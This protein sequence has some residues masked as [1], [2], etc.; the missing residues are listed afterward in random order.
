MSAAMTNGAVSAMTVPR[1]DTA[2]ESV[3]R[4]L[5]GIEQFVDDGDTKNLVYMPSVGVV[6]RDAAGVRVRGPAH[7]PNPDLYCVLSNPDVLFAVLEPN[8]V[9]VMDVGGRSEPIKPPVAADGRRYVD[10]DAAFMRLA[11]SYADQDKI[12]AALL[13][14]AEPGETYGYKQSTNK[15]WSYSDLRDATVIAVANALDLDDLP[16]PRADVRHVPDEDY[17][18]DYVNVVR[19]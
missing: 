5:R 3:A 9:G 10:R 6:V 16:P 11:T 13:V 12:R 4:F 14:Y 8:V 15:V 2:A 7:I 18:N 17:P 19:A 1:A